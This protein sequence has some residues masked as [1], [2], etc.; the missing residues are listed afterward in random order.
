MK[1]DFRCSPGLCP[2]LHAAEQPQGCPPAYERATSRVEHVDVA[3]RRDEHTGADVVLAQGAIGE[4]NGFLVP[5][6]DENA[7]PLVV[8]QRKP[9][10]LG[11]LI[12][13]ES[14]EENLLSAWASRASS[15]RAGMSAWLSTCRKRTVPREER[16][17]RPSTNELRTGQLRKSYLG[18]MASQW[19][20]STSP[21]ASV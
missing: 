10:D 21:V 1:Q 4:A 9:G 3:D 11:D 6:R 18:C 8:F 7:V 12:R 14:M 2:T 19:F 17:E 16:P 15:T 20:L 13:T 5:L